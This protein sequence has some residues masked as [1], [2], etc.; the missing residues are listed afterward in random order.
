MTVLVA[1]LWD[2]ILCLVCFIQAFSNEVLIL[3]TNL[4]KPHPVHITV[5]YVVHIIHQLVTT[6]DAVDLPIRQQR[7]GLAY[8]NLPVQPDQLR[9]LFASLPDP[10]I[11]QSEPVAFHWNQSDILAANLRQRPKRHQARLK[12]PLLQQ[13]LDDE[14][15][16]CGNFLLI[17]LVLRQR[18]PL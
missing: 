9:Q 18:L 16:Y 15:Y 5:F 12:S 11:Y 1:T 3:I 7:Y 10:V 4:V 17:I 6:L 14:V 8:N 13:V 2:S